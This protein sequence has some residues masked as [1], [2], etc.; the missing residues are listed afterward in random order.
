MEFLTDKYFKAMKNIK[1]QIKNYKLG[2]YNGT[3]FKTQVNA[4][5][6]DWFCNHS[7]LSKKTKKLYSFLLSIENK[8]NTIDNR[9]FFKNNMPLFG[10]LYDSIHII[11]I[12]TNKMQYIIKFKGRKSEL[13]IKDFEKPALQGT[14][15]EIKNYF[16]NL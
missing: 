2:L 1:E 15:K 7:E 16:N 9:F 6:F 3:S 4:G 12:K 13:Y 14:I 11:D 8:I 10:P 5:W